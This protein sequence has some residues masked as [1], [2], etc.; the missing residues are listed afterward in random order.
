MNENKLLKQLIELEESLQTSKIKRDLNYTDDLNQTK[1]EILNLE[2]KISEVETQLIN[3]TDKTDSENAK[4]SI[5][6]QFQKYIDEIGKKPNYLHLSRSQSMIKNIV[7]GLICKDIYYLV[8]DKV[9]GIHIPKYLI[10]TSNPEDSVNNREL[11]DFLSSEIAIVKSITKP[12]YVQ[13]RQYFE[14]FK[15]RMFNKFM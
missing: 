9:Y 13:L 8:Q 3:C 10:Y 15:D 11:I 14:E 2:N 7:F 1:Q 6:D 4:F 12:D 5:I